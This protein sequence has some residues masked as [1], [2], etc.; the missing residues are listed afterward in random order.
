[1]YL[2]IIVTLR[3]LYVFLFQKLQQSRISQQSLSHQ[4]TLQL[5][6]IQHKASPLQAQKYGKQQQQMMIKDIHPRNL[7]IFQASL[8]LPQ[9]VESR[10]S[11]S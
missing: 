11:V 1:M 9:W 5:P 4:I 2:Q 10:R 3:Y 8:Q 6:L 7:Y